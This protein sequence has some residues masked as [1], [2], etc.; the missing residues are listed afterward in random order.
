MQMEIKVEADDIYSLF[1]GLNTF[2]YLFKKI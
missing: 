2:F 1:A